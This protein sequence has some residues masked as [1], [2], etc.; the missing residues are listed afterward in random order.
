V[1]DFLAKLENRLS[2]GG[3]EAGFVRT[4]RGSGPNQPGEAAYLPVGPA[5]TSERAAAAIFT[6]A[7]MLSP[8]IAAEVNS[9]LAAGKVETTVYRAFG[10]DAR[11]QGFSWTTENPSTVKDFRNLVGLPSGGASGATNS[12]EFMVKGQVKA[13]D[14]IKTRS[15]LPL[16]GNAGGLPEL[17]IDPKN[18][19]LTDFSV[20]KP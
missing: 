7:T 6:T 1:N 14:I 8:G 11:A 13:S 12:A 3:S 19:K 10:G 15:A 20:L 2:P 9:V 5:S 16:D 4:T 18:V 17:I